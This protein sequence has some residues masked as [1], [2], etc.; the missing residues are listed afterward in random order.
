MLRLRNIYFISKRAK[1]KYIAAIVKIRG[2]M[3]ITKYTEM[4]GLFAAFLGTISL[5]PQLIKICKEKS[6]HDISMIMYIIICID[7]ILWFTYGLVLSLRPLIIQSIIT[8]VCAFAIIV[9]KRI[10]R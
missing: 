5:V 2:G 9:M 10:W 4:I 6:A 1:L 7:S 8:F 3:H